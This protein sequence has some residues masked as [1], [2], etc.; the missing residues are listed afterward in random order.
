M[1]FLK[2]DPT[3]LR[4]FNYRYLTGLEIRYMRQTTWNSNG[5]P[6]MLAQVFTSGQQSILRGLFRMMG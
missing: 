4:I 1:T 3:V 5:W 2:C 6:Q